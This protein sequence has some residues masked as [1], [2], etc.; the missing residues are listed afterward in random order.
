MRQHE[1][2]N[3]DLKEEA[4]MPDHHV[5]DRPTDQVQGGTWEQQ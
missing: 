2:N 1:V 3:T 4:P 5:S